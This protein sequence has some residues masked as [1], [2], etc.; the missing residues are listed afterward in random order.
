M[1]IGSA[2][3]VKG[4]TEE[5]VRR[6]S[7][8]VKA[9][10]GG[11]Y[12]AGGVSNIDVQ[13]GYHVGGGADIALSKNGVW[14][15]QPTLQYSQKGFSFGGYYGNEQ[16]MPA[17]YDTKFHYLE[18][19][20]QMAARLRLGE[21]VFLTFHFG[22][23]VAYG[24]NAKTTMTITDMDSHDTFSGHFSKPCVFNGIAY[25]K[26][27]RHVAYPKMRRWDAG[28]AGGVDLTFWRIIMGVDWSSGLVPV[29]EGGFIGNLVGNVLNSIFFG[30]DPC[31][32]TLN[33]S[34]GYQF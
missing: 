15:L 26:E 3:T 7:W 31:N 16:I 12:L 19:P 2:L 32:F 13:F 33:F 1:L 23:Y 22:P 28:L 21:D 6:V 20:V 9:G 17:D 18:M 29:C 27:N 34:L 4:Q 11:A 25:D 24:L 10:V 5:S 14:R 30:S 8:Q